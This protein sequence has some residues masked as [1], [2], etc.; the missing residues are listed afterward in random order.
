[1]SVLDSSKANERT[2]CRMTFG[3]YSI[4]LKTVNCSDLKYGCNY[5]DYQDGTLV[6]ISPGQVIDVE[7]KVDLY[8]PMGHGLVFHPD[9]IKGI[10]LAK[11]INEYSFFS[12]FQ[13]NRWTKS[14]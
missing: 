2:G 14:Q 4:F 12:F 7:N 9:L 6:F 1:V 10:S 13:E 8:Q 3:L 5:Y 11:S